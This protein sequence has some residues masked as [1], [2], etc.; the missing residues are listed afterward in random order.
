MNFDS[1][2][3][4]SSS[5]VARRGFG[6][7]HAL[8]LASRGARVVVVDSGV[9][10]D[11]SDPSPEPVEQVVKEIEAAGG[12][13]IGCFASVADPA[14]AAQAVQIAVDSFGGLDILV[15]NAGIWQGDWFE[16]LTTESF[17]TLADTHY[18]GTVHTCQAAWPYLSAAENGCIVNTSSEAILGNTP[19]TVHYSAAKGA[20]FGFTKAL[21]LDG[22][23]AGIRVNAI[24]PGRYAHV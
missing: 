5:R 18:M 21:A 23:R 16:N 12:E 1:T 14:G 7:C 11:G 9:Q 22:V 3:D 10:V 20:V 19:K 6:R 17:R 24:A 13:A 15:N 4:P 8:L 2:A